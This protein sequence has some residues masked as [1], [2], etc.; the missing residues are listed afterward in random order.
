MLMAMRWRR[1]RAANAKSRAAIAAR[2]RGG[3]TFCQG[4]KRLSGREGMRNWWAIVVTVMTM[5]DPGATDGGFAA[6]VVAAAGT[7]QVTA[8]LDQNPPLTPLP[9]VYQSELP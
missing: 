5:L 4:P 1:V 6:Q 2:T 3:T 7:E 8:T 9:T